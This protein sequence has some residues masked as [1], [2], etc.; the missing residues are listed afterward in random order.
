MIIG[1]EQSF[2]IFLEEKT[3]G[4]EKVEMETNASMVA[5]ERKMTMVNMKMAAE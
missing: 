4:N 3:N 2:S 5:N 1:V